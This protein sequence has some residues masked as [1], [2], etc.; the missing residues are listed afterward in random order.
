MPII[1]LEICNRGELVGGKPPSELVNRLAQV[2]QEP[3]FLFGSAEWQYLADCG[4]A[5]SGTEG[6]ESRRR[7][8]S[9]SSVHQTTGRMFWFIRNMF[10]GSYSALIL[11]K[12]S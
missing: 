1:L 2:R 8:P 4:T 10:A 9:G 11:A 7:L 3:A 6:I 12:R 5:A